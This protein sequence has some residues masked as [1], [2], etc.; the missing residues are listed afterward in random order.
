MGTGKSAVGKILA[1]RLNLPFVDLDR[2]IEKEAGWAIPQIFAAEGE[3]GFR[4]REAR[5]VREAAEL[6]QHVIATGGGVMLREEN[7]QRLKK[8]GKLICLTANPD[9]ILQRTL[10]TLPSRPLLAG[11]DPRERVD[12]LLKLR[13][14]FYAQADLT[15]DTSEKTVEQVAEEILC[16][17]ELS[18]PSR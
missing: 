9:V 8:S 12:Q 6:E 3:A 17:L 5:A 14:P 11:H 7:I 10:T 4:E 18:K 16:R 15:V 13:A 2:K 1:K